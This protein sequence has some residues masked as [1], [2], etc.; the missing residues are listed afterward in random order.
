MAK[1]I[2]GEE[3]TK[4]VYDIIYQAKKN[5]LIVSP[6]IKL[7]DYFKNEVFKRH[8]KNPELHIAIAFGKNEK[9][10]EKSF[11]RSDFEY[12]MEFPNISIVYIPK[13]HAKY[14]ANEDKGIITSINLYDYSFINNVEFGVL[15]ETSLFGN[16]TLDSKAWDTSLEILADNYCVFIRRPIFKKK[17]ILGKNYLSSETLFDKTNELLNGE[18]FKKKDFNSFPYETTTDQI[19]SLQ[20]KSRD[21]YEKEQNSNIFA[22]KAVSKKQITETKE[23]YYSATALGNLKNRTYNEVIKIMISNDLIV[24]KFTISVNGKYKG[25]KYESHTNDEDNKWIVYPESLKVLLD[26]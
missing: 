13:L 26:Y 15:S 21:K 23:L 4:E 7:D 11:K 20:R 9:N 22:K 25:L 12:F 16:N 1:F 17:L 14:Y 18:N 3:L 6:F 24:D 5:L 19:E 2:T 10:P 8:L